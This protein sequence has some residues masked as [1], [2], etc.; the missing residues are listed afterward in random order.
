MKRS[1]HRAFTLVELLVV[2]GIIA[3]LISILLPSLGRAREQA[4]QLACASQLRQ[5]GQ[6]ELM[7]ANDN[8]GVL[9]F[10]KLEY[11]DGFVRYWAATAWQYA[12]RQDVTTRAPG[13]YPLLQCPSA[14]LNEGDFS[15]PFESW[16][17]GFRS[18]NDRIVWNVCYSRNI[19]FSGWYMTG[20]YA[21]YPA[22]ITEIVKPAE[23]AAVLDGWDAFFH[24][25]YVDL[26]TDYVSTGR[27]VARYRHL[28]NRALNILLWDGHVELA[29]NPIREKYLWALKSEAAGQ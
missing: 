4:K 26:G 27:P 12:H 14:N 15:T 21:Y 22:K 23:K 24:E 19:R 29:T 17:D 25:A 13:N 20:T 11:P 10:N 3:L 18:E 6:I 16:P 2:I 7:Y 9:I 8:K 28:N 5:L 1:Q